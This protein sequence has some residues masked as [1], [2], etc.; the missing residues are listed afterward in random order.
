MAHSRRRLGKKLVPS[1][2][3]RGGAS[4]DLYE[5][6]FLSEYCVSPL[7]CLRYAESPIMAGAS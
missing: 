6:P 4:K 5:V 1:S 7:V 2:R 3:S